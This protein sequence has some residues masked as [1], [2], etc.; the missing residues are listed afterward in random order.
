MT[1]HKQVV[2][3]LQDDGSGYPPDAYER[4]WASVLPNGN[5][6]VDNIPFYVMDISSGDEIEVDDRNGELFF[7]R[8]VRLSG[9]STFRLLL[10]DPLKSANIRKDLAALGCETEFNQIAGVLAVEVPET[11]SIGPFLAYIM[12]MK[13]SGDIDVEE[14]ALRHNTRQ[15]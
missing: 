2:F 9:N 5:L 14:G 6:L 7:R 4:L 1:S 15:E 13:N 12:R 3:T 8:P 10:S 11:I